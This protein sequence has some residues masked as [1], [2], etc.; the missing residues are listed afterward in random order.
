MPCDCS[1]QEDNIR[2]T[3]S[4]AGWR[5]RKTTGWKELKEIVT[6]LV[7]LKSESDTTEEQSEA[8]LELYIKEVEEGIQSK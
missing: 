3:R 6:S 2:W 8:N 7:L 4:L 5:C 1:K